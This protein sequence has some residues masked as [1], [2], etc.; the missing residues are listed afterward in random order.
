MHDKLAQTCQSFKPLNMS[1]RTYQVIKTLLVFG[2]SL[3]NVVLLPFV[4]LPFNLQNIT[5][6]CNKD[7]HGS[8]N[9]I[10]NTLFFS[11]HAHWLVIIASMR[12]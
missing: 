8:Y 5:Y 1:L 4:N 9:D 3:F 11:S 6:L 10:I 7:A 2:V 12:N